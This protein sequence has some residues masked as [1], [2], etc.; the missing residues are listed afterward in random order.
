MSAS[1]RALRGGRLVDVTAHMG[2]MVA[3][4]VL[5][6]GAVV[7][8]PARAEGVHV[9][10][11]AGDPVALTLRVDVAD[12]FAVD[13]AIGW[14][15]GP[16]R[17]GTLS[18][19]VAYALRADPWSLWRGGLVPMVGVGGRWSLSRRT[20]SADDV[21]V[22]AGARVPAALEWRS[23]GLTIYLE[24]AP[25]LELGEEIR[26]TVEGGVGVRIEL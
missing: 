13:G 23:E 11:L 21:D 16:S 26:M 18:L 17:T 19:G 8:T 20:R 15:P 7:A 1:R 5:V 14:S 6:A 12:R 2:H 22:R 10:L 24:A 9:G 4:V 25:G 3:L